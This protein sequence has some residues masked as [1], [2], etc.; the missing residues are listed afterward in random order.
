MDI[1]TPIDRRP[2]LRAALLAIALPLAGAHAQTAVYGGGAWLDGP[3]MN[4][5]Q[6]CYGVP[7]PLDFQSPAF[8]DGAMPPGPN[9]AQAPN[10]IKCPRTI[11]PATTFHY[12]SAT[13]AFGVAAFFSGAPAAFL[14]PDVNGH[15]YG[16]VEYATSS[17]GLTAADLANYG[18]AAGP[19]VEGA[20][21]ASVTVAAPGVAPG[22]G[23]FVNPLATYGPVIQIPLLMTPIVIAYNPVYKAAFVNGR[24]KYYSFNIAAPN[25]DKSGGLKLDMPTLC[26]IFNG[27]ITNWNDPALRALNG[28]QSLQSPADTAP[29]DVPIELVGRAD[30]DGDTAILY[31]ALAAQCTGA[32]TEPAATLGGAATTLTYTNQYGPAGGVTL[33]ASL[34]GQ[35]WPG[36]GPTLIPVPGAFTVVQGAAGVATY[37]GLPLAVNAATRV[38]ITGKLG[39]LSPDYALTPVNNTY[40][41]GYHLN[42]ADIVVGAVAIEPTRQAAQAVFASLPPPQSDSDGDFLAGAT[43]AGLRAAPQDWAEPIATTETLGTG[44]TQNTPLADP[45]GN[46]DPAAPLYP[47]VGTS[48]FLFYTCYADPGVAAAITGYL[49]NFETN[50][51]LTS[52]LLG[53]G[54]APAPKA[55]ANAILATFV[56]PVTAAEANPKGRHKVDHPGWETDQLDLNILPGGTPAQATGFGGQC[57]SVPGAP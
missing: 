51:N 53:A 56:T 11:N 12:M 13:S 49:T 25:K 57:A 8:P 22:P 45:N 20:G 24:T 40:L 14:G 55:W 19:C 33:P 1:R 6:G 43:A 30:G 21:A 36:G 41:N 48:N 34:I 47:I 3:Y 38:A 31:R 27:A 4:Q 17:V 50:H 39:Y 15:E 37:L 16:G 5:T 26:A 46:L 18:C 44:V 32:Y 9:G 52:L 42:I 2:A 28:G 23:Q 35:T 54:F 29:F 7:T 10:P